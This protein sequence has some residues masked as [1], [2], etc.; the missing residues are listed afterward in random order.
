MSATLGIIGGGGW[1]GGAIARA[2]LDKGVI[3]PDRLTLSW[4]SRPP[5]GFAGVTLTQDNRALCDNADVLL[6]SVRP[7]DWP[8]VAQPA[9][10][11][12]VLSVM[13]GVDMA[14]L[15]ERHQTTRVIRALPNA[16]AEVGASY[17]PLVASPGATEADRAYARALFG[18]CG[19]VD[20]LAEEAQLDYLSGLTGTGPA[21]PA[22]MAMAMVA[23]ATARGIP[24]AVARRAVNMLFVGTGRLIEK[25]EPDPA[26]TVET[27]MAYR[28]VTA[29]GL[30]AMQGNGLAEAVRIGLSAA[31]ARTHAM[32]AAANS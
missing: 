4:R 26:A 21:Y 25:D 10:G 30:S 3:A 32:H 31:L 16:A 24:E 23:D 6:L 29:A 7:E 1:L 17:T 12:L 20:E 22:L 15:A 11:K 2:A 18:A 8:A 28:G 5:E 14:T 9:P 27:F 13:A 19:A